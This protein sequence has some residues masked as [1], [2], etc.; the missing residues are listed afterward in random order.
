MPP[1]QASNSGANVSWGLRS[2][3]NPLLNVRKVRIL[4]STPFL[5]I[6]WEKEITINNV[7]DLTGEFFKR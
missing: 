7:S 4:F 1:T 6:Y 5:N 3:L 2:F